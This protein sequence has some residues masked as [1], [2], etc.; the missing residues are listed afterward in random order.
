M[1]GETT[2]QPVAEAP[3]IRLRNGRLLGKLRR[4]LGPEILGLLEDEAVVEVLINGDGSV[5]A[6]R[7]GE[8][9]ARVESWCSP[10][11]T[12]SL[13]GTVASLL[14]TVAN[15]DCPIVEGELPFF[16]YR[17]EGVVPPVSARAIAA[18]RKHARRLFT[19]DDY[20]AEGRL[21]AA[22]AEVLRQ[23]IRDRANLVVAGGTGSGKTTLV[24]ALLHEKVALGD[25]SQRFVI[26][27]DTLELQCDAANRI[28][29][30]TSD[31]ADLARLVRATMRLRPDTIIVG[32][33]RGREALDMLK[34][35]NT[36]HPGG[37]TTVHANS[38]RAALPRLDQ[39][40][41]EA[42]VPSQPV[43][44]GETV[45]LVVGVR[46]RSVVELL[47]VQWYDPAKQTFAVEE[48]PA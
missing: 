33:V 18:I 48:I 32:E 43:L 23:A 16:G 1:G 41:Q 21:S 17:F 27:E 7:L 37:I 30:R 10:V 25:A 44:V 35:W 42:G 19:L 28:Q 31:A 34:A 8:G 39:L 15:A 40:L 22:H 5:W 3:S 45:D 38:S 4:E 24:N 13:V 11:R 46:A 47:R 20:L 14:G 2:P 9:M 6:D 36:G 29:L 12:Q 26:L